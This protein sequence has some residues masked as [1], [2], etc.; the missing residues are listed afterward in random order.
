VKVG[1][2]CSNCGD[3]WIDGKACGIQ[4]SNGKKMQ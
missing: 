4:R 3:H 1:I 2:M